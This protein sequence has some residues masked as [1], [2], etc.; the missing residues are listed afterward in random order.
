MYCRVLIPV[1]SAPA[2]TSGHRGRQIMMSNDQQRQCNSIVGTPHSQ[3]FQVRVN[4]CF[5][6]LPDRCVQ[7]AHVV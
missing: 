6:V 4:V 7:M 1:I 2:S 3:S 5:S